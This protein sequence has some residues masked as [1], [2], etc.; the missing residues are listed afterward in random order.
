MN[1]K[2]SLS[3][4][5]CLSL[6]LLLLA[7][8]SQA[9]GNDFP[10]DDDSR[11]DIQ[12]PTG[13]SGGDNV[14]VHGDDCDHPTGIDF[15][16]AFSAFKPDTVML[17]TAAGPL[18]W[19]ELYVFLHRSVSDLFLSYG[20]AFNWTEGSD[21]GISLSDIVLEYSTDDALS[22]LSYVYGANSLGFTLSEDDLKVFSEDIEGLIEMYGSKEELE[23]SLRENG[24]FYSLD[25]FEKL[26]KIE[27]TI[28]FLI[29]DLFGD[30]ASSFP[31]ERVSEYAAAN[32][33]MMAM[34]ILRLKIE[35]DDTPLDESKDILAQLDKHRD[36]G[37]LQE[38]FFDLM[39]QHSE[40]YGGLA[41]S[42]NGYL[43]QFNDMVEPFSEASASLQVGQ[44]SDIVETVY[45]Y[46]IILRIPIDYEAIPSAFSREG[47]YRTLRQAA[48]LED[49]DILMQDWLDS[50]NVEFTPEYSSID[51]SVIFSTN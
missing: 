12:D 14:H 26:Y 15:T 10:S 3:L 32:G 47:I 1:K 44:M 6:L 51:L 34:H 40:D 2:L 23:L 22:F 37:D 21:A 33:Y 46:H 48:A 5:L 30:N 20:D 17:N 27:F 41:S 45:G 28:G 25:V 36:S 7:G 50:L 39:N 11:H 31:D 38:V 42:P 13:S 43:F 35:G 4:L 24:G 8:C 9:D 19:A 49:F 16:A 29:N 18:T